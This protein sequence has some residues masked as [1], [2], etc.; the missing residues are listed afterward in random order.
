MTKTQPI[1]CSRWVVAVRRQDMAAV[2]PSDLMSVKSASA[3]A[4]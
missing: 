3:D 1:G 2:S 4:S